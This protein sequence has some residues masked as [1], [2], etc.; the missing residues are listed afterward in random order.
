MHLIRLDWQRKSVHHICSLEAIATDGYEAINEQ[1]LYKRSIAKGCGYVSHP[2]AIAE[3]SHYKA[4]YR[5][6][7]LK[8]NISVNPFTLAPQ[9][10][11]IYIACGHLHTY[12]L[13]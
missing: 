2:A 9:T 7:T 3:R 8:S 10:L 4:P 1:C 13:L 5:K 6:H 11:Y 12:K